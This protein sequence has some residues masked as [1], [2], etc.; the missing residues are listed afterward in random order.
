MLLPALLSLQDKV[1]EENVCLLRWAINFLRV[2]DA[3]TLHPALNHQM[4]RYYLCLC[5]SPPLPGNAPPPPA[6]WRTTSAVDRPSQQKHLVAF[7]FVS[8][9][10]QTG[11]LYLCLFAKI[12]SAPRFPR[13]SSRGSSRLWLCLSVWV[14]VPIK[15]FLG[16][17]SSLTVWKLLVWKY[18][19][20]RALLS[21]RED[22][23]VT[24]PPPVERDYSDSDGDPEEHSPYK[25][26][27]YLFCLFYLLLFRIC[28]WSVITVYAG[29]A[30]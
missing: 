21:I 12:H 15:P 4:A 1:S 22:K 13:T 7:L 5:A 27:M 8:D 6:G 19:W 29:A 30:L 9:W 2:G 3:S 25:K 24:P 17:W 23:P 28:V 14:F 26:Q 18:F 20:P 10:V 11:K 16:L